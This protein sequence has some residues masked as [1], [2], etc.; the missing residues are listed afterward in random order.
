MKTNSDSKFMFY[1]GSGNYKL[2]SD[3][4]KHLREYLGGETR[5]SN[6]DFWEFSDDEPNT[7]LP[8]WMDIADKDV[9]ICSSISNRE[10]V[11]ELL[12]LSYAAKRRYQCRRLIVVVGFM[13]YRRQD[14]D[15][16]M[17]E[18]C[19]LEM[20]ID[21]LKHVGVD[22]IITVSPHSSE[23]LNKFCKKFGVQ[24]FEVDPSPIFASTLRT[25]ST[26]DMVCY[27]PDEGSIP[28]ALALAS[29]LGGKTIFSLKKR[30]L[31]NE[32]AI[33]LEDASKVQEVIDFYQKKYG[34]TIY[35]ALPEEI[36]GKSIVMVEDEVTTG[37]TAN[38]TGQRL[39][40]LGAD[41]L[42]LIATHPVLIK[43]WQGLLFDNNPF[44]KII[45]GDTIPRD[46]K[47][48]TGGLIH[49]ITVAELLA[50]KLYSRLTVENKKLKV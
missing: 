26:K 1:S 28:R 15:E 42:S 18:F 5:F 30:G 2:S 3:I 43:N 9:V 27:S 36:K 23:K 35:Y 22:E 10:L 31:N 6:I 40:S 50:Q 33:R 11:A 29:I 16:R 25:Y 14:H 4:M 49:D 32:V 41:W 48:R 12:D 21:Q 7:R 37:K 13:T 44:D 45:M 47:K 20:L 39:K 38:M 17:E 24:L 8:Q 34:V 46:Y 19:R